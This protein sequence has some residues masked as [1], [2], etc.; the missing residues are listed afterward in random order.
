MYCNEQNIWNYKIAKLRELDWIFQ[1]P[2]Q[3]PNA[4]T[5]TA[6]KKCLLHHYANSEGGT[7]PLS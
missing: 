3:N 6:I 4:P 2:T 1:N 5:T 7:A